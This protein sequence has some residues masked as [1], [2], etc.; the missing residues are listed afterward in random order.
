MGLVVETASHG[1][2]RVWAEVHDGGDCALCG[3][4]CGDT[5]G[6]GGREEECRCGGG[7]FWVV[8]STDGQVREEGGS[9][10]GNVY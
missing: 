6:V 8:N 3:G 4:G 10:W 1:V 2:S 7:G 9:G 5:G